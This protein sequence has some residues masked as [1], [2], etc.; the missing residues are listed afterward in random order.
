MIITNCFEIVPG[1]VEDFQALAEYHYIKES[2]EPATQI[3][4][5][6][7]IE[8]T[9]TAFPDPLAVIVYRQPITNLRA[10]NLSTKGYFQKAKTIPGRLR[11][12]NKKILYLARIITDPRFQKMGMAT[13]LLKDTLE[14][15]TIPI[16]E[17]LTPID[18]TNKMFQK[19][20]FKL[21]LQQAP[22][23][24]D[25]F[26]NALYTLGVNKAN[27]HLPVLVQHRIDSLESDQYDFIQSEIHRFLTHFKSRRSMPSGIKRT[28]FF[29]S[30]LPFPQAYLIWFNPRVPPYDAQRAKIKVTP[31]TENQTNPQ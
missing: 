12:I 6:R 23:W 14:R 25:R 30:K 18:F 9:L 21:H 10:R 17:T 24:Y 31:T 29:L 11:I 7:G 13:W 19:A 1:T 4:K 15:Q 28:A 5:I 2:I 16:V 22:N 20:G 8:S 27:L 26:E 3:Y